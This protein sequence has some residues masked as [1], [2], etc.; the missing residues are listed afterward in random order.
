M[1]KKV[2]KDIFSFANFEN[3]KFLAIDTKEDKINFNFHLPLN[4]QKTLSL[5]KRYENDLFKNILQT[6]KLKEGELVLKKQISLMLNNKREIKLVVSVIPENNKERI[7]IEFIKK[8]PLRMRLSQLGLKRSDLNTFKK[9]LQ[10]RQGLMI[11]SGKEQ[12][13]ISTTLLSCLSYLN[14]EKK[15]IIMLGNNPDLTPPGVLTVTNKSQSLNYLSRYQ[16]DVIAIDDIN[17]SIMLGEAFKLASQGHLVITTLKANTKSEL[18]DIIKSA[19]WPKSEKL[20]ILS[21]VSYQKLKKLQ[22][23]TSL[24]EIFENKRH[25]EN[26]EKIARFK[27]I[28]SKY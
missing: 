25:K 6:L 13:G 19:P 1:S 5:P 18:A 3:A 26:R 9:S 12:E 15:N 10:K 2:I 16:A 23:N 20:D 24:K 7:V 28:Y 27:L 21:L 4:K 14:S 22:D 17:S 11:L 8:R